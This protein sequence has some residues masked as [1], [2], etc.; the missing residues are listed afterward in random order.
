MVIVFE[1]GK[2]KTSILQQNCMFL[3]FKTLVILC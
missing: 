1:I 3:L 2:D